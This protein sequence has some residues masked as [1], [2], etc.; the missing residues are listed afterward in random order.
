MESLCCRRARLIVVCT[1]PA[2]CYRRSGVRVIRRQKRGRRS[3]NWGVNHLDRG[4]VYGTDPQ[5][6]IQVGESD[7][8]LAHLRDT[9]FLTQTDTARVMVESVPGR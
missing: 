4:Q 5:L 3:G 1:L 2:R 7:L 8:T 9:L 6:R